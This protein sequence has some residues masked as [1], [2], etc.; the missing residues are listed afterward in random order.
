MRDLWI[1]L[2]ICVVSIGL[3]ALLFVYGPPSLQTNVQNALQ[4]TQSQNEGVQQV[5]FQVLEQGAQT[6]SIAD[7]TNYRITSNYDLGVLW[8]LIYGQRDAPDIPK[9][10]FSKYEV[11]GLFDGT[12]SVSGYGIQAVSVTDQTPVRTLTI[13]HLVPSA[14]CKSISGLNEPFELIQVPKTTFSLSHVDKTGTSSCP[15][16]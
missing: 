6:Y 13:E 1:L 5:Q 8:P 3:G 7:R 4:T 15:P 14:S 9:I 10:D 16:N 2:C 12:H 11:L